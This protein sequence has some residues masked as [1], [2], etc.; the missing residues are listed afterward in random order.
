MPQLPNRP[1]SGGGSYN[2]TAVAITGGTINGV[3]VADITA[4]GSALIRASGTVHGH[5]SEAAGSV[6]RFTW[7][8]SGAGGS[9]LFTSQGVI[10]S[11]N[12]DGE[13]M[14]FV[15]VDEA[16][17]PPYS[18]GA[19][20]VLICQFDSGVGLGSCPSLASVLGAINTVSEPY[21][22]TASADADGHLCMTSIDAGAGAP[23]IPSVTAVL[24][25]WIVAYGSPSS[26]TGTSGAVAEVELV[27][28][29]EAK[30]VKMVSALATGTL[31]AAVALSLKEDGDYT[32]LW[33]NAGALAAPEPVLPTEA[34]MDEWLDGLT[35]G[36]ALVLRITADPVPVTAD[37]M[38][39]QVVVEQSAD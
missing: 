1:G 2:P 8:G 11:F 32:D 35:A 5:T 34:A 26:G 14:N 38:T 10:A 13:T 12:L 21:G 27:A 20:D 15:A 17:D 6:S 28:G 33:T 9:G 39:V 23:T 24:S 29:V 4:G 3:D 19:D 16:A 22:F 36:E 37:A 30:K 25:E 31:T 18:Q 7:P